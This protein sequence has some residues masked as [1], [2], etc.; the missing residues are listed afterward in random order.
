LGNLIEWYD[1]YIYSFGTIYFA[2]VFFPKADKTSQL[3]LAAGV[4]AAGFL[5][6]P[7]GGWVFGRLADTRGRRSALTL[8]VTLMCGGSLLIALTPSY[9]AIGLAAPL[10]L[11]VARLAQGFSVGGEYGTSATYLSELGRHGR[12]GFYSS[13]Q[14]VTLIGG[15]L[16]ALLAIVVGQALLTPVQMQAW[17]WRVPFALG[18][19]G[20]L[21]ALRLR[22]TLPETSTA[23]SRQ[24][25]SAGARQLWAHWRAILIV[26]GLTAG[27]SLY[28][29]TF[30]TYMQKRLVN[31]AGFAVPLAS[32]VMA[33]ALTV[34]MLVQPLFGALADRIGARAS[35]RAFAGLGVVATVP[36]LHGLAHVSSSAA[37]TAL[38]LAAL[39]IGSL[40]SAS[41][42][43]LKADLFPIEV[44]A[45]GVGLSYAVA[46]AL[47]GGTAEYVALWLKGAGHEEYF[48]WY[49]VALCAVSLAAAGLM[50]DPRRSGYLDRS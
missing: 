47:F 15:Q 42:A 45:L 37:A 44:R 48:S 36:I 24:K 23:Q 18:A 10:A 29:Y 43:M 46:N 9:A 6:R 11:L 31:T 26:F 27:G 20:A 33:V 49:V 39:L 38:I 1:F 50:P 35:V 40:N 41:G 12:R 21:F 28:F 19:L 17:G 14:Y 8:S 34:Y 30:T 32:A 3:L 2:P 4:F 5:M 13:F 16:V 25:A 22:L 7:I